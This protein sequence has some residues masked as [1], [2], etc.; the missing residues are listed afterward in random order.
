MEAISDNCQLVSLEEPGGCIIFIVMPAQIQDL[1]NSFSYLKYIDY[2]LILQELNTP[3]IWAVL[4]GGAFVMFITYASFRKHM[5]KTSMEGG[6]LGVVVGIMFTLAIE[7]L[8]IYKF[9]GVDRFVSLFKNRSSSGLV[10]EIKSIKPILGDK[11]ECPSLGDYLDNLGKD[12][13]RELKLD[14]CK[15]VFKDIN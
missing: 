10:E 12:N 6:G 8:I 2:R 4:I 13:E 3:Y 11:I 14:L 9:I 1:I 15:E 7:A 5:F